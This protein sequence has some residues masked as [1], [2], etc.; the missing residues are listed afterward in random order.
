MKLVFSFA[1][2]VLPAA[3]GQ[4]SFEVASIKPNTSGDSRS[5]TNIHNGSLS[6]RNVTLKNCILEAY[7][8]Q[9]YQLQAP[10][11]VGSEAFDIQAKP[12]AAVHNDDQFRQMLQALLADRFKLTVHGESKIMPAYELVA[13]NNGVRMRQAPNDGDSHTNSNGGHMTAEHV[14]MGKLAQRLSRIVGRP[15]IDETHLTGVY[16][17]TLEWTPWTGDPQAGD[18]SGPSLF[19]ALQEQLGLKLRP[20]KLPIEM[21]VVDHV[22]KA[23]T[24]N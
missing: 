24:G 10:D 12:A 17:F 5:S 21:L 13:A 23:P 7:A 1:L 20:N 6:M 9:G 14:S 4:A 22:E 18:D 19:S 2:L 15:V 8:I 11:W 3:F 16:D